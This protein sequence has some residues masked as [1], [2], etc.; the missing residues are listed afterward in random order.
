M[1]RIKIDPLVPDVIALR[2]AAE[3]IRRDEVVVIPTDTLYGISA[4]PF[5]TVAVGR[6]FAVKG[7]AEKHPLPLI[8]GDAE[9][10][11][12]LVG[13][14]PPKAAALARTFWPG[15]LTLIVAAP[16]SLVRE[17]TAGTGTVGVRVPDH[18]VARELCRVA[19]TVLTA[20]S[21]N[22][23]GQPPTPDP[24]VVSHTLAGRIDMLLDAGKTAGGSPSTVIDVT[25]DDVRLVRAGAVSWEEI[26]RCLAEE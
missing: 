9:Q 21:A 12:R 5:S 17:V 7:R 16:A 10:V 18:A 22:I 11:T 23:S 15:P 8:A 13:A 6:V 20:T 24:D 2:R 14:L 3:A 26:Q 19:D 25:R 4:N 1:I